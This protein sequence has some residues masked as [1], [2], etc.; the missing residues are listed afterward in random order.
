MAVSERMPLL[1]TATRNMLA[2]ALE[3]FFDVI[4]ADALGHHQHLQVVDKL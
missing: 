3:V 2:L 4:D 1:G